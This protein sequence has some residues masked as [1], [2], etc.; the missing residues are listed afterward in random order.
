MNLRR[1]ISR[2]FVFLLLFIL[3]FVFACSMPSWFPIKMPIKKGTPYKAKTK[4]LVDKEVVIIDKEEYVKVLNP[5][6]S[7]GKD[8]PKYL[9]IP[10]NEYLSKK[11]TF[12]TPPL[13]VEEV[14]KEPPPDSTK[15]S[16]PLEGE[17]FVVSPSKPMLPSLKKKLLITYFDDRTTEGEEVLGD[18]VA[19]KL[20][21]EVSR[22]S[23]QVLFVDFQMI[24]EFLGKRGTDLK[25]LETPKVL[26]LLNE[27]FG[28]HALVAGYLSGPYVFT[29]KSDQ[30]KAGTASA[31]IKI[32]MRLV[33]TFS[34]KILKN[35]SANNPIVAAKEKG[36]FP[37]EK[38]KVKAIDF[39]IANLGRSLARELDSLDWFC[40]VAKVEGEEVYINA[41][42]LTGLKVGDVME[43]FRPDGSGER[44]DIKGKIKISDFFGIDA[45]MGRLIQG[46][47]PD[48]NDILKLAKSEGT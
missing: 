24:K 42:K 48:V 10:V 26:Q 40:R 9:Y 44:G 7:E 46:K 13:R 19:E 43:V 4:E 22:R 47:N 41:G 8:Q 37:E 38:A 31:I 28:V 20:M 23:L 2:P 17:I 33:D 35:L 3:L 45:S 32:D 36:T 18:W 16:S 34:G 11:E 15:P 6:A 12:T 39:T 30:D 27:V 1:I 29:S 14:K 25:D 5:R 21:K